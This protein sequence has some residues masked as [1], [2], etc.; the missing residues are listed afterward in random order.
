MI[1]GLMRNFLA[2]VIIVSALGLP[3][4]PTSAS[5]PP[6]E[7]ALFREL[8]LDVYVEAREELQS[9]L[10]PRGS[11]DGPLTAS[12]ETFVRQRLRDLGL[13][14][15]VGSKECMPRRGSKHTGQTTLFFHVTLA[16]ES[17]AAPLLAAVVVNPLFEDQPTAPNAYPTSLFRCQP[18]SVL[19]HCIDDNL[20][21]YFDERLFPIIQMAWRGACPPFVVQ[22]RPGCPR[23]RQA[24]YPD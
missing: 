3:G 20:K 11:V 10:H 12:M 18:G 4:A 13:L 14:H 24:R 16:E 1:V 2:T 6:R 21:T 15:R 19:Q 5:S 23:E 9:Q 17:P 8:C 22:W 7:F